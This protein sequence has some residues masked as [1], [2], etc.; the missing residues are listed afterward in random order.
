M[1]ELKTNFIGKGQVKGFKFTQV[2]KTDFGHIYKVDDFGAVWYEVFRRVENYRYSCISYPTNKAFGVWAW[3]AKS[4]S[5]ANE[6][7]EDIKT[8]SEVQNV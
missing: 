2:K 3:T 5:R 1:K 8:K 4:L 7:L 6:I